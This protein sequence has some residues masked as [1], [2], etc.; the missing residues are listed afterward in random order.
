M[1]APAR[2]AGYRLIIATAMGIMLSTACATTKMYSE[3]G[4]TEGQIFSVS[5]IRSAGEDLLFQFQLQTNDAS[6]RSVWG[7]IARERLFEKPTNEAQDWKLLPGEIP[8]DIVAASTAL[9][10]C[11]TV[12]AVQKDSL[13]LIDAC[14]GQVRMTI[15]NADGEFVKRARWRPFILPLATP[16]TVVYDIVSFP[17]YLIYL[18]VYPPN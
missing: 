6:G 17:F 15:I 14:S 7:R 18:A 10:A 4:V 9:P 3:W 2:L 11:M 13:R 16:L 5:S 8:E 12:Q 1:P